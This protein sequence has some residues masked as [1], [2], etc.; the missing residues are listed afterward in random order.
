MRKLI[1]SVLIMAGLVIGLSACAS[2]DNEIL[3]TPTDLG[4]TT[5]PMD[6]IEIEQYTD[7]FNFKDN[8]AVISSPNTLN[9]LLGGSSSCPPT[10]E[11]VDEDNNGNVRLHLQDWTGQACSRDMAIKGTQIT[12]IQVGFDFSDKTLLT[13]NKEACSPLSIATV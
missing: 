7:A 1:G 11:S 13:C 10:I 12:A 5:R 6:A 8:F 9:V 2:E 3:G 4:Y